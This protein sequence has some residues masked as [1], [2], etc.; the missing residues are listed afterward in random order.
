MDDQNTATGGGADSQ[1]VIGF[2]EAELGLVVAVLFMALWLIPAASAAP[3]V[4]VGISAD[5]AH[6]LQ[7]KAAALDSMLKADSAKLVSNR[8]GTCVWRR[9][10][11]GPIAQIR[12][13]GAQGFESDGRLLPWSQLRSRFANEIK[14]GLD[15]RC[16]HQIRVYADPQLPWREIE[17]ARARIGQFFQ[18][19]NDP[20]R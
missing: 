6:V 18:I 12:I 17:P 8:Q 1:V 4:E 11:R 9:I 10:V 15:S 13:I 19:L 5:S 20:A 3:P 14:Q 16:V 7:A 2:T